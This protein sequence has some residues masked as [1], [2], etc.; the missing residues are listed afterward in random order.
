MM[1]EGDCARSRSRHAGMIAFLIITM[2]AAAVVSRPTVFARATLASSPLVFT[3]IA[4]GSDHT[5]ALTSAG[6][7]KC[8]GADAFGQL[9]D[10][11]TTNR[12][13][14]GDVIGLTS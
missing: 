3:A 2:A 14:P 4:A 7:V 6:G 13:T 11:T 12:G 9:G 10:G 8:W 1:S 5:C